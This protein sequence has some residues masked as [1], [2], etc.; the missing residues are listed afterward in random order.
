MMFCFNQAGEALYERIEGGQYQAHL[1]LGRR[2][3]CRHPRIVVYIDLDRDDWREIARKLDQWEGMEAQRLI[4][5]QA[6]C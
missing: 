5:P 2:W 4:H 1:P 6:S 3:V